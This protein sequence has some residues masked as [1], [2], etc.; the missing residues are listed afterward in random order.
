[1]RIFRR[2]CSRAACYISILQM[3]ALSKATNL[4]TMEEQVSLPLLLN[5][6]LI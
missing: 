3:L 4:T 6:E 1:M 5:T 2:H